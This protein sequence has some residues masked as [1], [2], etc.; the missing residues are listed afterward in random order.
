MH[1]TSNLP[2]GTELGGTVFQAGSFMAQETQALKGGAAD[3]GPFSNKGAAIASGKYDASVTMPLAHLEPA[4]VRA[5]I[6][7]HGEYLTGP[8]VSH[9]YGS[10]Y[11]DV[12]KTLLIK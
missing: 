6:G 7:E 4:S 10:A 1:V 8:L 3:F 11:V 2:D 9:E 5:I 12:S